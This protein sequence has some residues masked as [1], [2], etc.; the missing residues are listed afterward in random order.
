[1]IKFLPFPA[2]DLCAVGFERCA[3]IIIKHH[4]RMDVAPSKGYTL[5]HIVQTF[6]RFCTRNSTIPHTNA[7]E[8]EKLANVG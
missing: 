7:R 8:I 3:G 4:N 1:V 5:H 2:T 6:G